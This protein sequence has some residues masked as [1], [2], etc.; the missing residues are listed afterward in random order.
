M[1]FEIGCLLIGA[2]LLGVAGIASRVERLPLTET[3]IYF[4]GGAAMGPLGLG[5][6]SLDAQTHSKLLERLSEV[7]VI[8]SLFTAGL[9]L[10][11]P[12]KDIKWRVP[13]RLAFLSMTLTV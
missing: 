6:L 12:L 11:I 10:R 8:V 5:L 13:L 4:V 9:K 1:N 3:M 2:L 7:A